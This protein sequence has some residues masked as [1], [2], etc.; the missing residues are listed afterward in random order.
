M[1]VAAES[2]EF[3]TT[4]TADITHRRKSAEWD[5]LLPFF[6]T[7]NSNVWCLR[8]DQH[9][10]TQGFLFTQLCLSFYIT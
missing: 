9:G 4:S 7:A 1:L 8:M 5:G 6:Y 3:R 10:N 2:S